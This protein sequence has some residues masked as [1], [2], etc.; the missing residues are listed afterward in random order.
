MKLSDLNN[1]QYIAFESFKKNGDPVN[2]P[3]WAVEDDG[4]LYA[5]TD[6]N[7]WKVRRVRNNPSVRVAAS[8]ARGQPKGEWVAAQARINDSAAEE[9]R[10]RK[11][12]SKKYGF[13]YLMIRVFNWFRRSRDA[14]VIEIRDV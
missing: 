12:L 13:S 1:P 4:N 2:T 11:L 7:S 6:A 5:W 8:D 10:I 9:E 14:T 3:L